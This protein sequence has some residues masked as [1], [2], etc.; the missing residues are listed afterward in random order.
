MTDAKT[1]STGAV[2]QQVQNLVTLD[3]FATW[4]NSPVG[5][6]DKLFREY[7]GNV[8]DAGPDQTCNGVINNALNIT[9]PYLI[10]TD[11]P[12]GT[13]IWYA[14]FIPGLYNN[15]PLSYVKGNLTSGTWNANINRIRFFV[16]TTATMSRDPDWV[17][18]NCYMG[19]YYKTTNLTDGSYQG[20]HYYHDCHTSMPA[21]KWVM[22]D[23][24]NTP[25]HQVGDS[26]NHHNFAPFSDY[27]DK[28]TRWYFTMY[29]D[30]TDAHQTS[31]WEM[32]PV[33]LYYDPDGPQSQ[34]N[35]LRGISLSHD[36]T[37]YRFSACG[38][39][40]STTVFNIRARYDGVPMRTAGFSTG[41]SI[42]SVQGRGDTYTCMGL[43]WT[44]SE[45]TSGLYLAWQ[46]SGQSTFREVYYPYQPSPTNLGLVAA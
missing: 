1:T 43:E 14:Q 24:T 22:F 11:N 41:T 26:D 33:S 45:S 30:Y 23:F 17:G 9:V 16:R 6:N 5:D 42:G 37:Q 40:D 36:G 29:G 39:R 35:D 13:N 8:R 19:T 46:R 7:N 15:D 10:T 44:H 21:N 28:E 34:T 38:P 2:G 12:D 18:N 3:N 4:R 31:T 27:F 32:G 20:D 25:T